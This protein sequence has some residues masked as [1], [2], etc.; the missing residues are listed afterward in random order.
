MEKNSRRPEVRTS[1]EDTK[2][3]LAAKSGVLEKIGVP[4]DKITDDFAT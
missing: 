4:L 2:E 1:A 3:L